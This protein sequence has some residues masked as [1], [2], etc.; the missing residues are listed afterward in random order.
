[1]RSQRGFTLLELLITLGLIG[2]V[3][4]ISIPVFI[5]SSA[6]NA[7]W[8]GSESIGAQ[9]RQM[10]LKAIS[11]NTSFQVRF[12]CPAN[13]QFR[14]LVV[15]DTI[16]DG[17]RCGTTVEY[18]SGV[19]AMPPQV[20]VNSEGAAVPN[21]EVNGRGLFTSPGSIPLTITVTNGDRS[22]SFT[23]RQTGQI[24]FEAF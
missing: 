9:I 14:I 23:I 6:R 11:R 4:A 19:F 15:D 12:D 17:G 21:I 22:R 8:T 10:R 24:S 1:M 5:E 18:D 2:I 3:S 13:G 16:D 7:V 20:S